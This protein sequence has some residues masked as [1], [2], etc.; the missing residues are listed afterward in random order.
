[1]PYQR[2][3]TRPTD[4]ASSL[5]EP[6]LQ[7]AAN[8]P[9]SQ[10]ASG[11][12]LGGFLTLRLVDQFSDWADDQHHDALAHQVRAARDFLH[13]LHPQTAET[14]HLLEIARVADGVRSSGQIRL[15]F[16]PLL[17][18]AYWLEHELRLDEALDVLQ[19]TLA[20]SDGVEGE[21]EVSTHLQRGRVLRLLG[22][23]PEA[24]EAYARGGTA[25]TR[26]GDRHSELLS[27]IGRAIVLQKTGNM[28]ESER[29]LRQVLDEAQP[30]GDRDAEARAS[31][32]LS[33]ALHFMGR[34]REAA[35]FA[36]KAY[37][38]YER[39]AQRARALSDT[40]MILK[41]L[42]HYGAARDAL[43]AVLLQHPPAEIRLRALVEL[44]EVSADVQDRISFERCRREIAVNYQRLPVDE[45]VDF[46]IKLATGLADFGRTHEGLPHLERALSLAEEHQLGEH[47]FRAEA[48]L[49]SLR[50]GC[51]ATPVGA[52]PK[53]ESPP[54]PELRSTIESLA[55]IAAGG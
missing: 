53:C 40:G 6:F 32:D 24:T 23:F 55:A 36:F 19:S 50:E 17:A 9:N 10:S 8:V 46:D 38:L 22:R 44:M 16:P 45:Q 18:F 35:T 7:R 20:L 1:M 43:H 37:Q 12:A 29:V 31:H 49:R 34:G 11:H 28:P 15:L 54:A 2:A 30:S 25:A 51:A 3:A 41:E 5:H 4:T 48:A 39:P 26:L 47:L 52:A 27:R 14:N 33:T 13:E 21:E 42:G